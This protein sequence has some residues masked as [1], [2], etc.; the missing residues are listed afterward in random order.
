[1]CCETEDWKYHE[2]NCLYEGVIVPMALHGA[3]LWSM[4]SVERRKVKVVEM[5][6]LRS[7]MGVSQMDEL[8]MKRRCVEE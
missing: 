6:C 2:K 7:W 4:R 8:G 1:M 5:K 3:E